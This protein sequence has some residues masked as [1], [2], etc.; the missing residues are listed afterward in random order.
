MTDRRMDKWVYRQ[1]ALHNRINLIYK[2]QRS[3]DVTGASSDCGRVI[4][5][6]SIAFHQGQSK[7]CQP[8]KQ[9]A[10]G[11]CLYVHEHVLSVSKMILTLNVCEDKKDF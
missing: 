9:E 1:E 10:C 5:F 8:I 4:A 11:E 2:K 6:D 7:A 3:I